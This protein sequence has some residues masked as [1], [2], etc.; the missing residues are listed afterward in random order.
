MKKAYYAGLDIAKNIFRVFVAEYEKLPEK[1]DGMDALFMACAAGT[2]ECEG[3]ALQILA[4]KQE[5]AGFARR[6]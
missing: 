1:I 3:F 5:Q 6:K 2:Y 4:A